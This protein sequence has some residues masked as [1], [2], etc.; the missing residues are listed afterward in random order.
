MLTTFYPAVTWLGLGR[1]GVASA[2]GFPHCYLSPGRSG[3]PPPE[4]AEPMSTFP[5]V[6]SPQK[7]ISSGTLLAYLSAYFFG[8][9]TPV[10][11][12]E[13]QGKRKVAAGKSM[14]F[15]GHV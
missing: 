11:S 4:A 8:S 9:E 14:L 2:Q 15:P 5:K 3:R 13:H 6:N 1:T 10:H 12:G 7:T